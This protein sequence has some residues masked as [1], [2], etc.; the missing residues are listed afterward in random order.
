[1]PSALS[2]SLSELRWIS[3]REGASHARFA[4]RHWSQDRFCLLMVERGRT[5]LLWN[6]RISAAGGD[7]EEGWFAQR[8]QL[9]LIGRLRKST[10]A[11][12]MFKLS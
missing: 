8:S 2:V 6:K 10:I 5:V 12:I 3:H 9:L 4:L 7:G 11:V 1:M